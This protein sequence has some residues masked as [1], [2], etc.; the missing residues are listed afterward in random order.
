MSAIFQ[1]CFDTLEDWKKRIHLSRQPT[2]V[3]AVLQYVISL[4]D[5]WVAHLESTTA[6][7]VYRQ[8]H[9]YMMKIPMTDFEAP[10]TNFRLF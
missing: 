1:N 2:K 4:Y 9:A 5:L 3:V 10:T 8:S 7:C 6:Q